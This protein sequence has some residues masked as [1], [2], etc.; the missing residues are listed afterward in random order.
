MADLSKRGT[1]ILL[2]FVGL[3]EIKT[4]FAFRT[5]QL[6]GSRFVPNPEF[7]QAKERMLCFRLL[8]EI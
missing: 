7:D 2:P 5:V 6:L 8:F 3:N 1:L 4:L